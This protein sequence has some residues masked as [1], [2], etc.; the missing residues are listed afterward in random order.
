MK[1]RYA[2]LLR[3]LGVAF[4]WAVTVGTTLGAGIL[5]APGEVAAHAPGTAV[6]FA[7]WLAGGAYA[8]LGALS[9]AELGTMFPQSGGQ[10]VFVRRALG[11]FPGFAVAWSDWLSSS[12][13]AAVIT[14]VLVEAVAALAPAVAPWQ[15]LLAVLLILGF[16]AAQWRGVWS[17]PRSRRWRSAR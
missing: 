11:P 13:S 5:R 7:I 12:A 2:P 14:I 17:R 16:A 10:T 8:L 9:L 1:G 4:G 6:F 3:V 15:R